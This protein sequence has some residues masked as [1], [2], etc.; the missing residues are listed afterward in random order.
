[1]KKINSHLLLLSGLM[2]AVT[3]PWSLFAQSDL[4]LIRDGN[5]KYNGD[6]F[7]DAETSYRKSLEKNNK[8]F[9]G[10]F[11]L[12]DALYKQGKYSEAADKFRNLSSQNLEKETLAK[13]YH[14][15]GN[16][17]LKDQKLEESVEAYKRA[18]QSNP[19][20]EDTRYNLAY[21]MSQMKQEQQQK[22]DKSKDKKDKKDENKKE[23]KQ[24]QQKEEK[25]EE[26]K[27][28]AQ[29]ARKKEEKISKEDAE[30]ILQALNNQEKE[31]QKKLGKKEAVR[32]RIEK[33]W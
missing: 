7:S 22:D 12:G 6:N 19:K 9:E 25:A 14:N 26:K 10:E 16:S 17:L 5:K 2:L 31:A 30:R 15:L 23:E 18:L 27:Q 32:I 28:D 33:D 4:K 11:N 24:E 20:D 13:V 29:E 8:S 3:L 21:A 1:M